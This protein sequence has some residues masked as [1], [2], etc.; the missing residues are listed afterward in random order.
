MPERSKAMDTTTASPLLLR[1]GRYVAFLRRVS[2]GAL[3]S[4][5]GYVTEVGRVRCRVQVTRRNGNVNHIWVRL[6]DVTLVSAS[7]L[8]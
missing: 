6:T 7:P 8:T 3:L 2:G 4:Y 5:T 1:R